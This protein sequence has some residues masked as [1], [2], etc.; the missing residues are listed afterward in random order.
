MVN[1]ANQIAA[2]FILEDCVK[3]QMEVCWLMRVFIPLSM[4]A[5]ANL[6]MK[7]EHIV[8]L[9]PIG[10]EKTASAIIRISAA[11]RFL[12]HG[13]FCMEAVL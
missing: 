7:M 12:V 8:L 2:A 1:P 6:F 10:F 5:G 13:R 9:E 11:K 3:L 4:D